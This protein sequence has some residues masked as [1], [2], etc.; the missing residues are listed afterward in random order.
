[1]SVKFQISLYVLNFVVSRL[2]SICFPFRECNVRFFSYWSV[3]QS[4]QFNFCFCF[5]FFNQHWHSRSDKSCVPA[6]QRP[7]RPDYGLQYLLAPWLQD[8]GANQWHGEC[9]DSWP[10][11]SDSHPW[12]PAPASASTPASFPAFSPV[13]SSSC[14]AS[15]SAPTCQS[16][17]G[18]HLENFTSHEMHL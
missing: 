18:E 16:Q 7:P 10:G 12:H 13:S 15:S 14:P 1:M 5:C 4:C 3:F 2:I 17:Q 11:S 6:V 8:W 9:D